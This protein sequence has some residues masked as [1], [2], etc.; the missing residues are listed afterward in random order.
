MVSESRFS[1]AQI[2]PKLQGDVMKRAVVLS[3]LIA[4]I[5]LLATQ[6][7]SQDH[8]YMTLAEG[9]FK[10]YDVVENDAASM[11]VW[12]I[13]EE[14][15]WTHLR[16]ILMEDGTIFSQLT[17]RYSLDAEGNVWFFG[18]V[19]EI[20]Q[21]AEPVLYVDAP[22]YAGKAWEQIV[23][24]PGYPA[25]HFSFVC[26]AEELVTVPYGMFWCFRV[27]T[28]VTVGTGVTERIHWYCDGIG[29]VKIQVFD[30]KYT[31][32]LA[33]WVGPSD[34]PTQNVPTSLYL[35]PNHPNPFNPQTTI[36]FSL[37]QPEKAEIA[38]YELSGRR[39]ATLA[40]REFT[41]GTH[42]LTWDGRDFQDR[43]MPSGT[44]LVRLE[45]ESGVDARKVT[46]LR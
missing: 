24:Y 23:D 31:F 28:T 30:D 44:F 46:L 29:R 14:D 22:L 12:P 7:W 34:V 43:A 39:V 26:E 20:A 16:T 25:R 9:N 17:R 37:A 33:D 21:P 35:H 15:G 19:E 41:A 13:A 36:T 6:A 1:S 8:Y 38:V 5:C 42:S 40:D 2:F 45:S 3:L 32:N 27:R 18:I 4:G 10:V 11:E